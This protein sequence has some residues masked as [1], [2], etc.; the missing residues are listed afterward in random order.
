MAD[1]AER[2]EEDDALLRLSLGACGRQNLYEGEAPFERL[3]DLVE[4]ATVE[5]IQCTDDAEILRNR[6][7]G[8]AALN[9]DA[10]HIVAAQRRE[11]ITKR[12]VDGRAV[13]LVDDQP[14]TP[15]RELYA[16]L[17][18]ALGGNGC[19]AQRERAPLLRSAPLKRPVF[20]DGTGQIT[21]LH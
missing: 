16:A 13:E 10:Q 6:Q 4:V 19:A 15:E 7:L 9:G 2:F 12:E 11:S 20:E 8:A 14:L 1:A 17:D 18:A 21:I 3:A 5:A